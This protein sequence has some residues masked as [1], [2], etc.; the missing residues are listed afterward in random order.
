M[1]ENRM[2]NRTALYALLI[3]VS[4]WL[5]GCYSKNDIDTDVHENIV[6]LDIGDGGFLS[7]E[8]CG[9]PC[10]W[11]IIPG[12]STVDDAMAVLESKDIG[13]YCRLYDNDEAGVR[14]IS[15]YPPVDL[16]IGL[17]VDV[18]TVISISFGLASEITVGDVIDKYGEPDAIFVGYSGLPHDDYNTFAT[19]YFDEI[20]TQLGLPEQESEPFEIAPSTKVLGIGYKDVESYME[21]KQ[22]WSSEWEGYGS[23]YVVSRE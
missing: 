22:R 16:D 14:G 8:P 6:N 3:L 13:G 21:H 18:D 2:N 4:V 17:G 15:C 1:V 19:L 9:P 10:F 20:Y 12:E 7:E 5:T 23:Y 11:N